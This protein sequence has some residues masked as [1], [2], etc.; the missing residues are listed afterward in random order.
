[1]FKNI[2][3]GGTFNKLHEG[4]E[5]LIRTA[6]EVAKDD[7]KIYIGLT[8]DEFAN[9]FRTDKVINYEERKKNLEN[10]IEKIGIKK[11]Y[12]ILKI[13]DV[14]GI[15]TIK[16]C[17]DTIV[18]SEETLARAEEINAIRFKKKLSRLIIIVVPLVLKENKPISSSDL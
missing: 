4:H 7:G 13:D 10:F 16:E 18:V 1:M 2:V 5:L 3:L 11:N 8:S 6:F 14:Y 17:L 9:K 12:E 15:A